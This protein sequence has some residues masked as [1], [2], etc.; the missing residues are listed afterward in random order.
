MHGDGHGIAMTSG[1]HLSWND[2]REKLIRFADKAEL[3][4]ANKALLTLCFSVCYGLDGEKMNDGKST[5]CFMAL[6]GSR[7]K[8]SR[9]EALTA[10]IVFYHNTLKLGVA[11]DEAVRRMNAAVGNANLFEIVS[12]E[13][14]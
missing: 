2:L 6:V 12:G 4:K 10:F 9:P 7:Q 13:V 1:E 3:I 11:A 14:E 5:S 8:V